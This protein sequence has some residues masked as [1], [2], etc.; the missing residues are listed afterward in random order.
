MLYYSEDLDKLFNSEKELVKAEKEAKEEKERAAAAEKAK[1]EQRAARAKE[2]ERAL[3]TANEAQATAIK[4]LKD[5]TKDYG[6]FHTSYTAEDTPANNLFDTLVSF[7]S[8]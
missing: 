2:V 3:K 7:L 4:M 1:K 6:Y 8:D 5:F